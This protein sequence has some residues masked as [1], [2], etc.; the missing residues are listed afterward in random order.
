MYLLR[1]EAH[2]R[3]TT[4]G[5]LLG[6]K[7]HTTVAH[8]CDRIAAQNQLDSGLR[9]DLNNIRETLARS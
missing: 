6:G 7:D 3:L 9:R 4:I 5:K 2:L 1:E 8:G